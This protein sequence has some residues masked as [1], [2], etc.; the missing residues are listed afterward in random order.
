MRDGH[1]R[2]SQVLVAI[3]VA[4]VPLLLSTASTTQTKKPQLKVA[5]DGLP[6]GHDTPEGAAADVV[7]S[8]IN[9]DEKLFSGTCIRLYAGGNG[10]S[11]YA[12]FLRETIQNIRQEAAKKVPSPRGPKSIG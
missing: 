2:C 8:L 9:R 12:Q 1:V 7:R 4:I 6:S 3:L 10:P 5:A 11:A